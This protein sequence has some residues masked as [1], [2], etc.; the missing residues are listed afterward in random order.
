MKQNKEFDDYYDAALE[1]L[2]QGVSPDVIKPPMFKEE[3]IVELKEKLCF[4]RN[5]L[6]NAHLLGNNKDAF[7]YHPN[8][9]EHYHW[10]Q[11]LKNLQLK[12]FPE[13]AINDIDTST[14]KI[15]KMLSH[16]NTEEFMKHGLVVGYVQSGKTANYTGLISKSIDCGY[17]NIIILS[18]IHNN[19]RDQ[20]QK[21]IETDLHS[22]NAENPELNIH[23]LTQ[24]GDK[25]FDDSQHTSLFLTPNPKIFIIKKNWKVLEKLINWMSSIGTKYLSDYPTMIID[26]E[27][28]NATID[29]SNNETLVDV[30]QQDFDDDPSLTNK[31]IRELRNLFQKVCYVGYT[32]TPF[33]NV[34]IDPFDEHPKHGKSL[35]PRDFIL[36]LPRPEGYTGTK[37]LFPSLEYTELKENYGPRDHIYLVDDGDHDQLLSPHS[38]EYLNIIPKSLKLAFFHYLITAV[39]KKKRELDN[40]IHSFLIHNNHEISIHKLIKDKFVQF[41]ETFSYHF[42]LPQPLDKDVKTEIEIFSDYWDKKKSAFNASNLSFDD[43]KPDLINIINEIRIIDINS[44]SN[45]ELDFSDTV[46]NKYYIIIGGNRLSRGLTIEGLTV[47]Y[48]TRYSN[49]YDSFLQMGRWF[50]F[51][52]GYED[53]VI[54]FTTSTNYYWF[55]WLSQVEENI[56]LDIKRYEEFEKTPLE[57][58]VRIKTHPG[59]HVTSP[60]KMKNVKEFSLSPSYNG[61]TPSTLDFALDSKSPQKNINYLNRFIGKIASNKNPEIIKKHFLWRNIQTELCTKFIDNLI[62][63]KDSKSFSKQDILFF[64]EKM[65]TNYNELSNWSILLANNTQSDKESFDISGHKIGLANRSKYIGRNSSPIIQQTKLFNIDLANNQQLREPHNPLLII[66]LI[67][68]DSKPTNRDSYEP[69]F[70]DNEIKNHLVGLVIVFPYSN[71]VERED[72]ISIKG[73]KTDVN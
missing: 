23:Y 50:G 39:I 69:W 56:R 47:T 52:K 13:I 1:L 55:N 46:N 45:D 21:R 22:L 5:T 2:A 57:L 67:D 71:K 70:K 33:A 62:I 18:G 6:S 61:R 19:L 32:A 51:R 17:R 73:V 4:E 48:F 25:D 7:W 29:V 3:Y 31:R 10:N 60:L 26:D 27:A 65:N 38:P 64:I 44:E 30:E 63:P 12:E 9:F 72:Y 34:L 36:S 35:Y 11:Y 16:P 68:A 58:A 43:I 54:V 28:D 15:L 53:L 14:S 40:S 24:E 42:A 20:T 41:F 49:F 59:M 8:S 66:H 37:E